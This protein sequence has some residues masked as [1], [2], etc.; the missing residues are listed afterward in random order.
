MSV[1]VMHDPNAV[2]LDPGPTYIHWVIDANGKELLRYAPPTPPAGS[3]THTYHFVKVSEG[4]DAY[5]SLT[6][7]TRA[8]QPIP[9]GEEL[10]SFQVSAPKG[11]GILS[12]QN[13]MS[14]PYKYETTMKSLFGWAEGELSHVGRIAAVKNPQIQYS[15]AL[16]TVNGMAHLKDALYELAKETK[17]KDKKRDIIRLH[18]QVIRVMKNLIRT[19]NIDLE[20]I[21]KFNVKGVLSNLGYLKNTRTVKKTS[22]KGTRKSK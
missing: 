20:P 1:I 13:R 17:S 19:Y 6:D 8:S 14:G 9:E 15:Y 12:S 16:S 21:R 3:G 18:D 5:A 22:K 7:T 4:V 2:R 10:F 11:G